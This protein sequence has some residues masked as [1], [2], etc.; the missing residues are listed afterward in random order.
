[1][2]HEKSAAIAMHKSMHTNG[3]LILRRAQRTTTLSL[4][5]Q[6][7]FRTILAMTE[8]TLFFAW[9]MEY[10]RR[11]ASGSLFWYNMMEGSLNPDRSAGP[12]EQSVKYNCFTLSGILDWTNWIV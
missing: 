11:L 9:L 2:S 6:S 1:M 7:G 12:Q 8:L 10:S 4:A 3:S 5:S